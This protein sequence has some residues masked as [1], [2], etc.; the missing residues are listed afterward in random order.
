[1]APLGD[2]MV[3]VLLRPHRQERSVGGAQR[4]EYLLLNCR[5]QQ[6]TGSGNF[7][8]LRRCPCPKTVKLGSR[9]GDMLGHAP[10]VR[11]G[12]DLGVDLAES[13]QKI[14]KEVDALLSGCAAAGPRFVAVLMEVPDLELV[15]SD[16]VPQGPAGG[17]HPGAVRSR[18][19]N[20][21]D[22]VLV[23]DLRI[24]TVER[25]GAP[26]GLGGTGCAAH[27]CLNSFRS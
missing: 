13:G 9:F 16:E 21:V 10:H 26:E 4:A 27:G 25:R 22:A 2:E 14:A 6:S 15:W 8:K 5:S 11:I 19:G 20:A 1:M 7:Q 3:V 12:R 24:D 17:H 23:E 18:S